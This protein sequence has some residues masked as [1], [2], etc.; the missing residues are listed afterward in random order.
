MKYFAVSGCDSGFGRVLCGMLDKLNYTVFAGVF[1]DKSVDELTKEFNNVI[2][3]KLDITNQQSVDNFFNDI[4]NHLEK[5]NGQLNGIVNNAGILI[6]PS[7]TE[8]SRIEDYQKMYDVNLL[9]TVRMTK[10]AL[11]LLRKSKGRIV[12]VASIAGRFGLSMHAAYCASKYAVE[13]FSDVL[14]RDLL[15]WGIPVSIIEPGVFS[16]TGL[17]DSF[18]VGLD[19]VWESLDPEIK[20]DYGED[21]YKFARKTLSRVLVDVGNTKTE[22]VPEAM[23]DALTSNKPKYRYKVGY[24]SQYLIPFLEGLHES[25]VDDIF[26]RDSPAL[27]IKKPAAAPE[28]GKQEVQALMDSGSWIPLI[29]RATIFGYAAYKFK[30]SWL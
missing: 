28:N 10:A 23:V 25:T 7:P 21:Y 19:K 29:A 24:D 11:P 9:G 4:K 12:N 30:Q 3:I 5:N 16:K 14:R 20:A 8:W 26:S 1:L 15:P 13:A 27:K 22:L 18:E 6:Q 17:Y 2:P